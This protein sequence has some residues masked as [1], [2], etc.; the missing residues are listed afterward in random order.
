MLGGRPSCGTKEIEMV[1]DGRVNAD[2]TSGAAAGGAAGVDVRRD[3]ESIKSDLAALRADLSALINSAI[4]AGKAQAGDATERLS[5]VARSRLEQLGSAWED[6][7]SHGQE[8]A[9]QAR[10]RIEQRPLQAVG[11]A[12]VSGLLLGAIARRR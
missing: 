9:Q 5:T 4:H 11:I 3:V 12:F 1:Q 8:M 2:P 7:S 6:V 10:Q